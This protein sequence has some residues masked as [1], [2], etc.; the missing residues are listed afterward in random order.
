MSLNEVLR[1]GSPYFEFLGKVAMMTY[2]L[3]IH[4]NPQGEFVLD[5]LVPGVRFYVVAGG[6]RREAMV[7][8]PPREPGEDRDLGTI[9][10]NERRR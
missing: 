1:D 3:K 2:W 7:A 6:G 5:T 4:P 8:V 10:L 9:T